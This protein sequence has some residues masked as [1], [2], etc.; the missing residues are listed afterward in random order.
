LTYFRFLVR[1]SIAAAPRR[2][3]FI[4]A[5]IGVRPLRPKRCRQA[6]QC[7]CRAAAPRMVSMRLMSAAISAVP[8]VTAAALEQR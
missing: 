6:P 8:R 3:E 2:T 7:N 5:E 4:C 1:F